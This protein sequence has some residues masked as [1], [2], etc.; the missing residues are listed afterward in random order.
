MER[1]EIR[2]V[3]TVKKREDMGSSFKQEV[4]VFDK[5]WTDPKPANKI[6]IFS[7]NKLV[8][9]ITNGFVYGTLLLS[10]LARCLLRI[11]KKFSLQAIYF[12]S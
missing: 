8:L 4:T 7:C 1:L 3:I 10:W 9:Q 11:R 5:I 2:K 6:V 12:T